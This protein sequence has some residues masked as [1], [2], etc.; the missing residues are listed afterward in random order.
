MY[1]IAAIEKPVLDKHEFLG[2]GYDQKLV[3]VV[4]QGGR[5]IQA[6]MYVARGDQIDGSLPPYAW[7][8]DFVVQGAHQHQL[9]LCYINS[10]LRVRTIVDPDMIR[11]KANRQLL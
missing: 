10:H 6:F 1:Q 3:D 8:V 9:P 7:Y 11:R 2:I 4:C 5:S